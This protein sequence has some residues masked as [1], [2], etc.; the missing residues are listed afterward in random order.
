MVLVGTV[1]PDSTDAFTNVRMPLG[2]PAR[3]AIPW[4]AA[5]DGEG[6]SKSAATGL[7]RAEG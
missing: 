3:G 7:L 5:E 4:Q 2:E 1:L 6:P